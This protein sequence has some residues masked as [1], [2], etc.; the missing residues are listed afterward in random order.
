MRL[1]RHMSQSLRHLPKQQRL[2]HTRAALSRQ[3]KPPKL[4]RAVC[5]AG[6]QACSAAATLT[7]KP[8]LRWKTKS[9]ANAVSVVMVAAPTAEAAVVVAV[10]VVETA[11]RA[12]AT[13]AAPKV[14]KRVVIARSVPHAVNAQSAAS[15]M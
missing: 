2:L 10:A 1:L 4:N 12:V 3:P 8:S 5:G 13:N 15:A 6:S 9:Q 14:V 11:L 7:T